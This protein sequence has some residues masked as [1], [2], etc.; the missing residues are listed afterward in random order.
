MNARTPLVIPCAG[1]SLAA[2]YHPAEGRHAL[3]FLQGGGQ[4]RAGPHSSFTQ[5]ADLL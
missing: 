2:T 4:T 3:L 5:L 1:D